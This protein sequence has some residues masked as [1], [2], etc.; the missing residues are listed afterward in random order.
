MMLL[1]I[2]VS[3]FKARRLYIHQETVSSLT[4]EGSY[5]PVF[6]ADARRARLHSLL[7]PVAC[8]F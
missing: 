5:E 2:D 8:R 7:A 4:P 1:I 6:R 3:S